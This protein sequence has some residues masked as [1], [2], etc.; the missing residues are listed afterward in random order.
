MN[1]KHLSWSK[2][3]QKIKVYLSAQAAGAFTFSLDE[4]VNKESGL[5]FIFTKIFVKA[6]FLLLSFATAKASFTP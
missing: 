5:I 2:T 3:K 6:K 4:K 1:A